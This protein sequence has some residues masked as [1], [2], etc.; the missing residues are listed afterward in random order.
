MFYPARYMDP[1]TDFGFKKLFASEESKPILKSFLFGLL[2]L[3]SPIS[4]ISFLPFEQLPGRTDERKSIYDLYCID[5][6]GQ[7]FIVEMQ[8]MNEVFLTDRL[9]YYSSFPIAQQAQKGKWDFELNPIYCVGILDF[10]FFADS[11][12]IH[13]SQ[14]SDVLTGEVVY[15]KLTFVIV[16]L[17]KFDLPLSASL[18]LRDKWIYFLKHLTDLRAIPEELSDE[19]FKAAFEIAELAAMSEAEQYYHEGS[20]NHLRKAYAAR[21]FAR[22]EGEEEGREEGKKEGKKEGRKEGKEEGREEGRQKATIEIAKN[23]LQQQVPRQAILQAT[24]LTSEEL[25][26]L[27]QSSPD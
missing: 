9:V 25:E 3:E 8:K 27:M 1:T 4:E 12:F 13:H 2:E 19:S 22:R 21:E 15:D 16:E 10:D 23:L 18:S 17:N 24:G 14:I 5:E 20:L 6:R 7:R 26:E 11:R